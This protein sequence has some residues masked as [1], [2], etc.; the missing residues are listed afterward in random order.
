MAS[1]PLMWC[2]LGMTSSSTSLIRLWHTFT[3]SF[4]ISPYDFSRLSCN[5]SSSRALLAIAC[6]TFSYA[7]REQ[8]TFLYAEAQRLRSAGVS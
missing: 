3:S 6:T 8:T 1:A 5:P 2:L 7:L 4:L